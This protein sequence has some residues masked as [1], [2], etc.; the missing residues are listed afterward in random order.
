MPHGD[1]VIFCQVGKS[2][3]GVG[4]N[5]RTFSTKKHVIPKLVNEVTEALDSDEGREV[6]KNIR[7]L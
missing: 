2:G 5:V 4:D 1:T 7:A 6:L 3:L